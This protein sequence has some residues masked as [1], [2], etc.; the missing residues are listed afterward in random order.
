METAI[1]ICLKDHVILACSGNTAFYYM[2]LTD[3]EDKLEA[4]DDHK[5]V[6]ATG[7]QG[8][9]VSFIQYVKCA[10]KPAMIQKGVPNTTKAVAN[11]MRHT[12]A[13]A[14]RS[15]GGAYPVNCLLGGYDKQESLHDDCSYGPSLFWLDYLG[16]MQKLNYGSHG[17]GGSFVTACLDRHYREDM[18][19]AESIEL[20]KTC[21]KTVHT[22]L[23]VSSGQFVIKI[24]NK[25]GV[26]IVE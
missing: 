5:V 26:R 7:E 11:F 10:M 20:M 18:T 19:E 13:G 25:D 2:V 6:A 24:I 3:K 15:R 1:G 4:L 16:S 8:G 21:I 12:L 22:R 14:L 9:R 17:Y 23:T